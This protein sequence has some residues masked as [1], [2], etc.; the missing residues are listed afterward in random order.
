MDPIVSNHSNPQQSFTN[1]LTNYHKCQSLS[2]LASFYQKST[3]W[4]TLLYSLENIFEPS[5]RPFFMGKLVPSARLSSLTLFCNNLSNLRSTIL[6][7]DWKKSN[8][9]GKRSFRHKTI[10][11]FLLSKIRFMQLWHN[12]WTNILKNIFKNIDWCLLKF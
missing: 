5:I 7:Q 3:R 8:S 1:R 9:I 6:Q 10:N 12:K 11:F 4:K 2:L